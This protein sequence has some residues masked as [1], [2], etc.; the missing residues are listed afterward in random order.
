MGGPVSNEY[1]PKRYNREPNSC[2]E[3]QIIIINVN[4]KNE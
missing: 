3:K 1:C 4:V 2:K